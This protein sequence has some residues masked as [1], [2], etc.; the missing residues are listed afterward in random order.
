[1]SID[2]VYQIEYPHDTAFWS[3]RKSYKAP[4]EMVYKNFFSSTGKLKKNK[5]FMIMIYDACNNEW[6]KS[7]NVIMMILYILIFTRDT[8]VKKLIYITREMRSV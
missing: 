5:I 8:K 3:K 1:L 7:N 4:P 2:G 6:L